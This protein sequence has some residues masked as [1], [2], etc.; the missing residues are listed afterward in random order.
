MKTAAISGALIAALAAGAVA[1][2]TVS[3]A[4][5]YGYASDCRR[6]DGT[7]GTI[8]GGI[9]GAVLGSNL[10]AHHGGRAGGAAI[11]GVAGAL[12]GN[13]IAR[14]GSSCGTYNQASGYDNRG[15][16]NQSYGYAESYP[17]YGYGQTY[18]YATYSQPYYSGGYVSRDRD[19]RYRG[20][21]NNWRRDRDDN[22]DRGYEH[23]H[24]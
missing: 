19:D 1:L 20:H 18:G 11:G 13:S 21:D 15:Y 5:P 14:S 4:Q 3:A 7:A 2:P 8:I 6:S 17:S 9:A 16:D 23:G 24:R 12:L 22:R 10:A